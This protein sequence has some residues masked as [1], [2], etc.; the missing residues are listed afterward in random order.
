M[1][2]N[3]VPTTKLTLLVVSTDE[4]DTKEGTWNALY[5]QQYGKRHWSNTEQQ[6]NQACSL[7]I[8]AIVELLLS[9]GISQSGS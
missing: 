2:G 1:E 6:K 9:E 7:I 8:T 5:V 3:H 4:W